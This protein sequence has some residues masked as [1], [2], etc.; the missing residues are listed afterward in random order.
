MDA[1]LP[2]GR[3]DEAASFDIRS[4]T[5][6]ANADVPRSRLPSLT[7]HDAT[8]EGAEIFSSMRASA[9]RISDL[10]SVGLDSSRLVEVEERGRTK[11]VSV[12]LMMIFSGA[13][14]NFCGGVAYQ[15]SPSWAKTGA[16]SVLADIWMTYCLTLGVFIFS[17][18]GS[19]L[20][21]DNRQAL[22]SRATPLFVGLLMLPSALDVII[23]GMSTLALAFA[24]PALVGTLKAAVQLVTLSVASRLVLRKSQSRSH[25]LCL[26]IVLAGVAACG[27]NAVA[28]SDPAPSNATLHEQDELVGSLLGSPF[29]SADMVV[30][31]ALACGSGVLGAWRNL[32]EAAILSEDDFPPNALLLAES[33]LSALLM[34][35]LGGAAFAFAELT[36]L[37]DDYEDDSFANMIGMLQQPL[38]PAVLLG[39]MLFSYGK[40]SGKF[41][42]IKHV[43]ALR[44][45]VLALLF[46]FGTWAIG[47]LTYYVGGSGHVPSIGVGWAMPSS[48][49]ELGGFL[50]I[51]G[52]NVVMVQLKSKAPP[53]MVGRCCAA[54]DRC[55][56]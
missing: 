25:W 45:K 55:R 13:T 34:L 15:L 38:A 10:S 46:P 11:E 56:C 16:A 26:L 9:N 1:L 43:S 4:N 21:R 35:V 7:L 14:M 49:I 29:V 2:D 33:A 36:P 24:Q 32:L 48:L 54:L 51:L 19:A 18:L 23:T 17:A 22:Y 12:T 52:A 37:A 40:D 5:L 44:Q 3:R 39:Y 47:L 20:S 27:A 6:L 8:F 42:L 53:G 41:W 30:G 31:V 28:S 50:L